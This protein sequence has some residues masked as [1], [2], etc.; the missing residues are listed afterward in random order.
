MTKEEEHNEKEGEKKDERISKQTTE[1]KRK[2]SQGINP[3]N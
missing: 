2:N 3:C 1:L